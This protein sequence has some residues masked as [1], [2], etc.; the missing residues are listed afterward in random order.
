MNNQNLQEKRLRKI[1]IS[2]IVLIIAGL[3]AITII[4][5]FKS[6]APDA[7]GQAKM[8]DYLDK[9]STLGAKALASKEDVETAFSGILKDIKPADLSGVLTEKAYGTYRG[10]TLSFEAKT[11]KED[12]PATVEINVL[13]YDNKDALSV[14]S[15]FSGAEK[16]NVKGVGERAR[17]YMPDYKMSVKQIGLIAV[18][19]NVSYK[20]ALVQDYDS[21]A[22]TETAAKASLLKLAKRSHLDAVNKEN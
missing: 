17:Y 11:V 19:E 9:N 1:A 20:F 16:E 14:D 10:E 7:S 3:T 21:R 15:P 6:K 22:V 12:R 4:V 8:S 2:M 18:K 13:V 5:G